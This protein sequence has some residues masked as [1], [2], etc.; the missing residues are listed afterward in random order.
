M[1]DDNNK[2]VYEKSLFYLAQ[3]LSCNFKFNRYEI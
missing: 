1:Y 3:M 2:S